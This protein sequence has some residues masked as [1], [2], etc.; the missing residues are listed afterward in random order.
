M[1]LL[2]SL[3]KSF[4]STAV[5]FAVSEGLLGL[6]DTI[7]SHF[8]E[9]DDD[10]TDERSRRIRVRHL[11]A[12]ASGHREETVARAYTIDPVDLVRGFLS[13]P[14]D[15]EPGTLFCYN[16]PCTFTLG[17]IVQ[18]A[19]GQSLTDYLRP[20]LFDPLGIGE[21]GWQRDRSGR[22][23]GF[24]GFHAPTSAVAKLGQLYLQ[25]GVWAGEQ[26]LPSGW[27][28]EATVPHID[29]SSWENP[30]WQQGY[31]FQ[32]WIARHGYRGDGAYGQFCV[33]LP[34]HDMVIAMTGQSIDMQ[35]V[36]DAAWT[37][38]LPAV[39]RTGETGSDAALAS[40]LRGLGLPPL[41]APSAGVFAGSFSAAR[42]NDVPSLTEATL[43]V[44]GES[45]SLRL[46][47]GDDTL[48]VPVGQG[49]WAVSDAFAVSGGEGRV[50][51]V[52][53]ETPHRLHL[54]F[55]A[56]E[57]SFVSRWATAPLEG[58]PLAALRMPRD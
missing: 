47:E 43:S 32:F 33:V 14:P 56:D 45:W 24:T 10:I 51:L 25:K 55:D 5:G 29:N 20:R 41:P 6:D 11:L 3:S 42:G 22:Q 16:Q 46:V 18:R 9:L 27:V 49:E 40:R 4:T 19:S 7:I 17:A 38:L 48:T 50:D 1:H 21:V 26:L 8:P 39:D 15:E 44:D 52:F 13:I 31:G 36:L 12:M 28:D 37:H 23:L 54:T 34:E 57:R 58:G 35:A 53:L 30:D 2:Y